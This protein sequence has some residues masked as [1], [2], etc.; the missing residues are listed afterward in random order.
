MANLVCQLHAEDICQLLGAMRPPLHCWS[1]ISAQRRRI[2]NVPGH[3]F[4]NYFFVTN[5]FRVGMNRR[6]GLA[7]G[8]GENNGQYQF[9]SVV[10][11]AIYRHPRTVHRDPLH[12]PTLEV[13]VCTWAEQG[14]AS[15]FV[16]QWLASNSPAPALPSPLFGVWTPL[17]HYL[18][19]PSHAPAISRWFRIL[20]RTCCREDTRA[21]IQL[22]I[23]MTMTENAVFPHTI[24]PAAS[25]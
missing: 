8:V 14:L 5:Q 18:P 21:K 12:A 1:P 25:N 4:A 2:W 24:E 7:R 22:G 19:S 17:A 16:L 13:D 9:F 6:D 11:R 20:V 15:T 23:Q 10:R 3:A